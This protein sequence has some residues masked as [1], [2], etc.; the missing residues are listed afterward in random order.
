MKVL[1]FIQGYRLVGGLISNSRDLPLL[2][3]SYKITTNHP[4][5][6]V[7]AGP[8]NDPSLFLDFEYLDVRR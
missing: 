6:S 3:Y 7:N 2:L 1:F 5:G 4:Y 8:L